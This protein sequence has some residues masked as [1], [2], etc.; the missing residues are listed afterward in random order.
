[1]NKDQNIMSYNLI[2]FDDELKNIA[3]IS[4]SSSEKILLNK[5][6][7]LKENFNLQKCE[8]KI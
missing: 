4:L 5:S 8:L 1:M 7:D 3:F 6:Y 2:K